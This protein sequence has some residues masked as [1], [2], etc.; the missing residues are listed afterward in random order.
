MMILPMKTAGC[1]IRYGWNRVRDRAQPTAQRGRGELEARERQLDESIRRLDLD[2]DHPT[3]VARFV[4]EAAELASLH[5]T[6]LIQID[7]GRA[8]SLDPRAPA[9]NVADEQLE[10]IPFDVTL[11]GSYRD[12]LA[13]IRDFGRS[14]IALRI[15][16]ASIEQTHTA[17]DAPSA[18]PLTARLHIGIERLRDRTSPAPPSNTLLQEN[19]DARYR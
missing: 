8:E 10:S 11:S 13:T 7:E 5:H 1:T 12:L 17:G 19:H 3:A 14:P 4:R 9:A 6:T 2:A 16:V 15:E 18:T